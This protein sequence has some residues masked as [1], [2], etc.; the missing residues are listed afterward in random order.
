MLKEPLNSTGN[1][2]IDPNNKNLSKS[3]LI[4]PPFGIPRISNI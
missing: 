4:R 2:E 1:F 3:K